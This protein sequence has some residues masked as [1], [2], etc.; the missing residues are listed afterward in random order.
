M[1]AVTVTMA[2]SRASR[3]LSL[4][5]DRTHRTH[6]QTDRGFFRATKGWFCVKCIMSI[7][8]ILS[9]HHKWLLPVT[10]QQRRFTARFRPTPRGPRYRSSAAPL[11][12]DLRSREGGRLGVGCS[13]WWLALGAFEHAVRYARA[14]HLDQFLKHS[15]DR[16]DSCSVSVE[17]PQLTCFKSHSPG[18]PGS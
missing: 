13:V 12:L 11:S 15:P 16:S 18:R 2:T 4:H 10:V 9:V 5:S 17:P 14:P 3:S 8:S 7:Y 1:S 6:S